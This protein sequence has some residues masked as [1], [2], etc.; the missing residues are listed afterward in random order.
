[1]QSLDKLDPLISYTMQTKDQD[2]QAQA[3][4]HPPALL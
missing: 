1:M 2:S 3:V 4:P